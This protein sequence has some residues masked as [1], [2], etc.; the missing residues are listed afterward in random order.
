[1]RGE[2]LQGDSRTATSLLRRKSYLLLQYKTVSPALRAI[3]FV[4]QTTDFTLSP[5]L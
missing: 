4:K 2:D 3:L 1:M 5:A